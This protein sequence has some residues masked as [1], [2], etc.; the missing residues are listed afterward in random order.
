MI[1]PLE[2]IQNLLSDLRMA[3]V[4]FDSIFAGQNDLTPLEAVERFLL[5]QQR[6]RTESKAFCAGAGRRCLR[7]DAAKL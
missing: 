1:T 7:K 3:Q 4:D 5:E 2:R 6:M